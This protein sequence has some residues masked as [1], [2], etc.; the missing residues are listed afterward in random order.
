MDASSNLASTFFAHVGSPG[1]VAYS[2]TKGAVARFYTKFSAR[3]CSKEVIRANSISPGG[4]ATDRL[5]ELFGSQ[6]AAD[7]YLLPLIPVG[8]TGTPAD[9]ADAVWFPLFVAI[10]LYDGC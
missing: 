8:R 1:R 4:V 7:E 6:Q 3:C 2:T 9:I 5:I 10:K